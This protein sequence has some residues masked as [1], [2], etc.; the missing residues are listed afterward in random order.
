MTEV[1]V[2]YAVTLVWSSGAGGT[3]C[4]GVKQAWGRGATKS[5]VHEKLVD[6]SFDRPST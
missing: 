3:T 4:T 5:L 1:V 2:I 6:I